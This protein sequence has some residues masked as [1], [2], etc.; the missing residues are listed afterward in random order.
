MQLA[1]K[2]V[3]GSSREDIAGWLGDTLKVRVRV[4]P[5]KGK[6]N[7]AVEQLLSRVLGMP[8]AA[9]NIVAGHGSPRKT[10]EIAGMNE[11]AV[12]TKLTAAMT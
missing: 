4:P 7:R 2:V 5:E 8:T 6:A 3:P 9:V 12:L 11:A 1:V 10:V